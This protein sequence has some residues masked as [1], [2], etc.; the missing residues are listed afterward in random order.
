[1][2]FHAPAEKPKKERDEGIVAILKNSRQLGV[3]IS[4]H[5]AAE[6]QFDFTEMHKSFET[7]SRRTSFQ[8][9]SL[10]VI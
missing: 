6:I 3:R 7:S 5:R 1:M 4:G 10:G 8:G 2:C 9:P